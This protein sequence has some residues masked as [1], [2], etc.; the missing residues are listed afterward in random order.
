MWAQ[1]QK[2]LLVEVPGSLLEEGAFKLELKAMDLG[3][4]EWGDGSPLCPS[5]A[6]WAHL[7]IT[8][9]YLSH[10]TGFYAPKRHSTFE[11]VEGQI[12]GGEAE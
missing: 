11:S 4:W 12:H 2:S 7:L 8:F 3:R 10:L 1:R 5:P 9:H 6:S